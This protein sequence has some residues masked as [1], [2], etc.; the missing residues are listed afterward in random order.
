M[1][2][3]LPYCPYVKGLILRTLNRS[4]STSV[5]K[6]LILPRHLHIVL[7]HRRPLTTALVSPNRL[8]RFRIV[9]TPT[10]LVVRLRTPVQSRLIIAFKVL[11]VR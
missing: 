5:G 4:F 11:P 2:G 10:G 7:P 8:H 9:F 3:K 6:L 1:G